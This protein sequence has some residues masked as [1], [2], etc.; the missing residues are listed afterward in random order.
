MVTPKGVDTEMKANCLHIIMASNSDW[1]VPAGPM[2][3]RFVVLDVGDK[4]IQDVV[5][6]GKIADA[7]R[8][9]GYGN[10]LHFLLNYD[11]SGYNVRDLPKTKALREQKQYSY[12]PMQDWW[13]TK[14]EAGKVLV[15]H[16]KWEKAVLVEA[17]TADYVEYARAFSINNRR[18]SATKLGI[19]LKQAC[20]GE[21]T[22][23]QG[24]GTVVINDRSINR[25]YYYVLPD[26]QVLRK[27]WDKKYGGPYDWPDPEKHEEKTEENL[28]F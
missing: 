22:R 19:F 28:P 14:L 2:E 6:F 24:S 17:L 5:Y 7:M 26:L 18:G 12:G 23:K 4:H 13:F 8:G 9:G 25:P 16:E 3:R 15:E 27:W 21:L 11:L 20:C 10:L 1:V